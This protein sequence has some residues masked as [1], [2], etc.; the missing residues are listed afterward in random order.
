MDNTVVIST[1]PHVKSRRTTKGIM[2][3]VI[4]ALAPA[5][6]AGI[7]FFGWQA[8][9]IMV[10]S[11][12]AA[13]A[14]EFV[15]YFIYNGSFTKK[16][17]NAKK[18]CINWLKQFDYTSI[19]TGLILALIV[20]ST[21]N[22]YEVLI[23][24]VFAILIVKMLFGG[25]GRNLVNPA[26]AG[27]VM[28]FLSFSLTAY[29]ATN[30]E[31]ISLDSELFTGAT[32]LSGWLLGGESASGHMEWLD[33][34]LGTGVAGCIGE[35]CKLALIVGY[36]YLVVRKVIKWWQPLL[37]IVLSAFLSVCMAATVEGAT[38][39]I[40]LMLDYALSGGLMFGAIFM[41][42][43]Y[44]T[45]PK[46][47]Y[48]QIVYYVLLAVL[49]SLLRFY[50]KIEVV[51]FVIM[52]MNLLVPLIDTYIVRKPFGYVKEKSKEGK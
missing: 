35:T 24:A 11:V 25:T 40:S 3:D 41:A 44:V 12:L 33:L 20:P 26:A 8:L 4:V 48:G 31:P 13:V 34:F 18:V 45:S 37:Y 27:R 51:S 22:W 52:L 9:V 5:A 19:V 46:G 38:F 29:V 43:D 17:V 10:T 16:C 28:M 49:T 36:I 47:L 14:A 21:V 42:T 1:P 6:I 23:G 15:Y 39:D 2:L 7:V 30:F 50:T 32:H